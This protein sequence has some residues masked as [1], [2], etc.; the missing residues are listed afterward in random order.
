[1]KEKLTAELE[2]FKA[3]VET[4]GARE[5]A[6]PTADLP[7]MQRLLETSDVARSL[8][9]QEAKFDLLLQ[10]EAGR[11]QA[12]AA[13]LGRALKSAEEINQGSFLKLLW[14][15]GSFWQPAAGMLAAACL[16]ILLGFTTPDILATPDEDGLSALAF[17]DSF[18]L[19]LEYDY[20]NI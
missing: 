7:M 15:F 2:R 17:G 11:P 19:D 13:L 9:R 3:V 10:R 6:W 14:P 16:G 20:E 4:Y 8:L 5:E 1:M 12:S 18:M